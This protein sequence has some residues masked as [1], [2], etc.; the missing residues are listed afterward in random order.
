MPHESPAVFSQ[1]SI[2]INASSD[3]IWPLITE[4]EKW[5]ERYQHVS[6]AKLDKT[7]AVG[8]SFVWKSGGVKIVSTIQEIKDHS[9]I[10]WTGKAFGTQATHS[11]AL[12]KLDKQTLLETS[13]SFDG[14]L[15]RLMPKTMQ[16]MLDQTL[17]EWLVAIKRLAE[18]N[19]MSDLSKHQ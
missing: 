3:L 5:P 13:E 15:V 4:I 11:W 16:K 10:L 14:W 6:S 18:S 7:F 12:K 17:E 1:K 8:K 9:F 2:L 19:L